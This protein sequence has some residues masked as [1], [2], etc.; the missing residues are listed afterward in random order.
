MY[1]QT[2]QQKLYYEEVIRLHNEHGYGARRTP[3]CVPF[4]TRRFFNL[5]ELL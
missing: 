4:G 2:K 1:L 3:P 5:Q